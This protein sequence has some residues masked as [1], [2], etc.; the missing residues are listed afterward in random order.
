MLY[1]LAQTAAPVIQ[2]RSW[3]EYGILGA[4][5]GVLLTALVWFVRHVITVTIPG[6]DANHVATVTR[7]TDGFTKEIRESREQYHAQLVEE[8]Q[9][10]EKRHEE[11]KL[12]QL[13]AIETMKQTAK[14]LTANTQET[15]TLAQETRALAASVGNL[16]ARSHP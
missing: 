15:R 4:I 1:L 8:R 2:E 10:C 12:F 13:A 6:M 11:N 16:T 7:I 3:A 14:E 5:V 9:G